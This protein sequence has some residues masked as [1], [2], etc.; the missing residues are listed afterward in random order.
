MS[1]IILL[2]VVSM[3]LGVISK[4][5]GI[6]FT[7]YVLLKFNLLWTFTHEIKASDP[8][9]KEAAKN[10]NEFIKDY[11]VTHLEELGDFSFIKATVRWFESLNSDEKEN[12][13][14]NLKNNTF[15]CM[16]EFYDEGIVNGN[17]TD[18]T[19]LKDE[20]LY[21]IAF[22]CIDIDIIV[23]ILEFL[24]DHITVK[25]AAQ[26]LIQ[27]R[28]DFNVTHLDNLREFDFI[29]N[30][31]QWFES[32]DSDEKKNATQNF[33]EHFF[34]CIGDLYDQGITN[35][36]IT[37]DTLLTEVLVLGVA[38]EC[39]DKDTYNEI[40]WFSDDD[41]PVDSAVV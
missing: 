35:G 14:Q 33:E 13:T 21:K 31:C 18:D 2:V 4:L 38:I 16:K 23:E 29:Q 32:L 5:F 9:V 41:I 11:D 12:A 34:G 26:Y 36:T 27:F 7:K 17:I 22:K 37:D 40:A 19:L 30:F 28:E 6:I 24:E 1:K 15:G 39:L 25:E 8:T 10:L 3:L 20:I